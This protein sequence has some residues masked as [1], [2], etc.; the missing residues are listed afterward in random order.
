MVGVVGLALALIGA[1]SAAPPPL[2]PGPRP[3]QMAFTLPAAQTP[4]DWATYDYPQSTYLGASMLQLDPMFVYGVQ[5]GLDLLYLRRYDAALAHFA[6]VEGTFPNTALSAMGQVL[7]WQARMLENFDF[8]HDKE[9]WAASKVARKQLSDALAAPGADAWEHLALAAVIGIE[10]IHDMRHQSYLPAL[11]LAF[12]AIDHIE[13]CRTFA[14]NFVDLQLADGMYNYWRTVVTQSSRLLPDFGDQRQLGIEQMSRVQRE[15][16]FMR[17]MA[18]L[19]LAYTWME[20][21]RWTDA[22]RACALNRNQFPDNVIN[23]T[24]C[25]QIAVYAEDFAG[26]DDAFER[27]MSVDPRNARVHYLRGWALL[28]QERLEEAE[29]ELNTYLREPYLEAWQR[30]LTYYR[31]GQL[32]LKRKAYAAAVQSWQAAV[33]IDGMKEARAQISALEEQRRAGKIAW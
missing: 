12:Q 26:A 17:P 19:A 31:L 30:S 13:S 22:G 24:I 27:I 9:Y 10:S 4:A 1:A 8:R 14:P 2:A 6:K 16:I 23:N 29:L 20:E 32:E 18:S 3:A 33:K 15:G 5:Q 7:V 11:Q 21:R 25:G 28:R